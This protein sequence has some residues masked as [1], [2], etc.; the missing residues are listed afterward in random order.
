MNKCEHCEQKFGYWQVWRSFWRYRMDCPS[1][2]KRN[3]VTLDRRFFPSFV[4][5]GLPILIAGQAEV[6]ISSVSIAIMC[7]IYIISVA[8]LSLFVP[9]FKLYGK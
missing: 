9:L 2:G 6:H 1:C 7:G 5:I 3:I 4:I 8:I